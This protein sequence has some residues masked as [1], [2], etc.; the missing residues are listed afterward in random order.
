MTDVAEERHKA[1]ASEAPAD[2]KPSAPIARQNSRRFQRVAVAAVVVASVPYLWVLW[3]LWTGTVDPLRTDGAS[4]LSIPVYDVQARA[5]LH[6][7]LS[8]PNGSISIEAFIHDGR[9]YTYFGIFPSLLRLPVVLFTHSLDGRLSAVSI[10]GSWLVTAVFSALLLWRIRIVA[11]G[12]A[13]L[14]W[15]EATSYGILLLSILVGSVLVYLAS[16]PNYL[17]ED[18]AWSV[19]LCS[20]SLFALLGVVERPSWGR[21][22]MSGLLILLSNLN[23]STTGYAGILAALL[24]AAWFALGRA[25][26]DRRR[27]AVPVLLAALVPLVAG[28]AIDFAKFHI[29]FGFPAGEQLLFKAFGLKGTN[30]GKYFSL[31]FLPSTLQA[32]VNPLSFRVTSLFPYITLPNNP[33]HSIAH[34]PLFTRAPTASVLPSMPL[35][36]GLGLWGTITTFLPRRQVVVRAL[37]LLIVS[38]LATAATVMIFGWVL[39]RYVGDFM[40]LFLLTSMIG[41]VDIWGRLEGGLPRV[42]TLFPLA[43]VVLAL[44]GLVANLG[45]AAAPENNWTPTQLDHYV[46]TEQGFSDVTGH[47]LSGDV[48]RA[49]SF[50]SKSPIGQ[51]FVEGRCRRLYVSDESIPAGFSSPWLLVE[52]APHTPLCDSLI[53]A[54]RNVSLGTTIVSPSSQETLSGPAVVVR[55]STSGVGTVSSV[56]FVLIRTTD[57]SSTTLGTGTR[58]QAGWTYVWDPRSTPNGTYT[59][60]SVVKNTAG[61]TASSPGVAVTVDTPGKGS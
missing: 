21:I 54:A 45:F 56:S 23:R 18:L 60:H 61:Y 25:G 10:L 38:T 39:E 19:A 33:P 2:S 40:P 34:T 31:R 55:A 35:M 24:I 7:H 58:T 37:R 44:F 29:L 11:R 20:G 43:V 49:N 57:I 42:R 12:D 41:M 3:D 9:T 15:A 26:P 4:N 48:V 1:L 14:G 6:G 53:T 47:P 13:A 22:A 36:F 30:G 17:S 52:R 32:Y 5:L 16:Q 28:C 51:L 27:W 46:N 8:L 50:P 59:L